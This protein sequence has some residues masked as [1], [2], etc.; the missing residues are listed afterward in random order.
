[1]GG[2]NQLADRVRVAQVGGTV[3]DADSRPY[4]RPGGHH[5]MPEGV[6]KNWNLRPETR[7][8]FEQSSTGP[9][10][11]TI[12]TTPEGVRQGNVWDGEGSLHRAYNQAVE[13]LSNRFI[14]AHNLRPDGSNMTP[15]HARALLKEIRESE[16]P[17]IRDFNLNMRRIQRLRRIRGGGPDDS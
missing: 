5:E 4:Y 6:R 1:M 8:V 16:D 7:K 13:E 14:T 17:R 12:R 3:T 10:G 15:D 2:Q 9:L 11:A